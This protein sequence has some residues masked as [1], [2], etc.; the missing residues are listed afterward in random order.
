MAPARTERHVS[1][2]GRAI[3]SSWPLDAVLRVR[4]NGPAWESSMVADANAVVQNC[5]Q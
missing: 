1:A 3:E 5:A 4:P 2:E